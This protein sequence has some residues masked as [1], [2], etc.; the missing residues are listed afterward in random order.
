[1]SIRTPL[2]VIVF[3]VSVRMYADTAIDL[4]RFQITI[5][6]GAQARAEIVDDPEQGQKALLVTVSKPG[7]EF[8]SVELRAPGFQFQ[9]GKQYELKFRA[10]SAPGE[11]V[12]F[13]AEKNSG[14][15]E[16][17][18][19]GTTLKIPEQWTDCTVVLDVNQN[20]DPGRLTISN[21]SVEPS[22]FRFCTFELIEK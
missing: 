17:V 20:G 14:N 18:A 4:S 1:M 3:S 16:S 15:Q 10:K 12:Y 6:K 19:L 7:P 21:L 2:L 13:V 5:E 8:W 22:S 9:A 11:Y